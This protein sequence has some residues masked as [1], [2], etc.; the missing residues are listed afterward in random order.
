MKK[1]KE[2]DWKN[3]NITPKE[4]HENR[5]T[6]EKSNDNMKILSEWWQNCQLADI[7]QHDTL[8]EAEKKQVSNT[9]ASLN[10][11]KTD[12]AIRND[13]NSMLVI[14]HLLVKT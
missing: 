10:G 13:W 6:A 3:N 4:H 8:G 7:F 5:L 12:L 9:S 14:Y 2:F 11:N 1:D